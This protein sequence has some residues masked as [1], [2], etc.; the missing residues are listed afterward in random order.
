M[1]QKE[2]KPRKKTCENARGR[3][4]DNAKQKLLQTNSRNERYR[5]N[6]KAKDAMIP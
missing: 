5:N 6:S 1:K 2:K 4:G 3:E